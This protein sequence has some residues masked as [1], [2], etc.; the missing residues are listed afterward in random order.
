MLDR[1]AVA[2]TVR[3]YGASR[4][5]AREYQPNPAAAATQSLGAQ[6]QEQPYQGRHRKGARHNRR[7]TRRTRSPAARISRIRLPCRPISRP[8]RKRSRYSPQQDDRATVGYG[9]VGEQEA[10]RQ[11]AR[12]YG[13][14]DGEGQ[15][16]VHVDRLP[17]TRVAVLRCLLAE[18]P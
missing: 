1:K 13:E 17:G 5:G 11:N 10:A 3:E 6:G 7:G 8:T 15:A 12:R 4:V 9:G 18:R 14:D 2:D 16:V